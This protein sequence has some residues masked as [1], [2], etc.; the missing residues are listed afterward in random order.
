MRAVR[1]W[2]CVVLGFIALMV[3]VGGITR[4]TE[5]GLSMVE[6]RPLIG[7][8]P[9]LDERAWHDVFAKYQQTPQYTLVNH[10][11]QLE[12]FKRIFFWEYIHRLLGRLL[13][14]VFAVPWL[15]FVARGQVRGPLLRATGIALLLGAAQGGLGWLMVMSGLVDRPAVSHYR[16]AAHLGLA[17]GVALWVLWI[18]LSLSPAPE[19][20]AS[21][22]FRRHAVVTLGLLLTQVVYGAFMAG[23]RAGLVSS[24]FPDMN[25]QFGPSGFVRS[26]GGLF[27]DPVA[28]HWVHRTLAWLV[29]GA[30][31]WLWWRARREPLP[32]R[33]AAL[34]TALITSVQ[35]GLGALTVVYYVPISVA[36]IHQQVALVLLCATFFLI[37][38]AGAVAPLRLTAAA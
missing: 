35:V 17:F 32:I 5:S 19:Q 2:L 10:W 14:L 21:R 3:A 38:R 34:A 36:V 9:P 13:G 33:K 15:V 11:M 26:A 12:D 28:I 8:L 22:S 18:I 1:I 16:L 31:A 30:F 29:L 6:W 24:T 7:A 37:F 25:G 27:S 4:L 20:R 23:K